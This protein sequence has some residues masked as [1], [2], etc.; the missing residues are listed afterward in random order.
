MS[1]RR[2]LPEGGNIVVI[3]CGRLGS[4]IADALSKEGHSVVVIDVRSQAFEQLTAE[5]S[6]FTVEADATEFGVLK[7]AR[8]EKADMVIACTEDDNVNLLVSQVARKVFGTRN[9]LARV[10]DSDRQALCGRLEIQTICPSR[11][12]GDMFLGA[13]HEALRGD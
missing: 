12:V 9:V 11:V 4:Y 2:F 3:G 13:V 10:S 7:N 5:F 8:M 1:L 6:G